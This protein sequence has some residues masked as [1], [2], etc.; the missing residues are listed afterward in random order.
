MKPITAA[1]LLLVPIFSLMTMIVV[2]ESGAA[3]SD[4]E[5]MT[6]VKERR[7]EATK[8]NIDRQIAELQARKVLLEQDPETPDVA[9]QVNV[10]G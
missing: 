2:G 8:Q 3:C 4:E 6:K 10:G 9:G 5:V 1:A 7:V